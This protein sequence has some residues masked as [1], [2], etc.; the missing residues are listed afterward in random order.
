MSDILECCGFSIR[1]SGSSVS[2]FSMSTF[3]HSLTAPVKPIPR[4]IQ[5]C[6][7]F[8]HLPSTHVC[9]SSIHLPTYSSIPLSIHLPS[10]H[11][12]LCT[13]LSIHHTLIHPLA[14]LLTYPH[15][16]LLIHA[17]LIHPSSA[18]TTCAS[19]LYIHPL[20]HLLTHLFIIHPSCTHSSTHALTHLP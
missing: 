19:Y 4:A 14:H 17:S 10:V 11:L 8:I 7:T 15:T 18:H 3:F 6:S 16:H 12:H 5:V 9:T 2:S 1:E 20:S 13:Y